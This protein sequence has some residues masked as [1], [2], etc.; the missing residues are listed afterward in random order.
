MKYGTMKSPTVI[1]VT[2]D[3]SE[4]IV[5]DRYSVRYILI[6]AGRFARYIGGVLNG[7]R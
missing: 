4:F 2:K 7:K 1:G 3:G 5:V 6:L